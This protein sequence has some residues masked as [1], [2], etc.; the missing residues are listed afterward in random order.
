MNKFKDNINISRVGA[1]STHLLTPYFENK[2]SI[3]SF[4]FI[5]DR[6]YYPMLRKLIKKVVKRNLL[7]LYFRENKNKQHVSMGYAKTTML[8]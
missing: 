6:N 1:I 8:F 2:Q 5:S 4:F 3:L 7:H